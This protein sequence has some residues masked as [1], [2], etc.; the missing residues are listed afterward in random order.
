MTDEVREVKR[1][2]ASSLTGRSELTYEF[3]YHEQ[4]KTFRFRLKENSGTGHFQDHWISLEFILEILENQNAAFNLDVFRPLYDGSV[5]GLGFLAACLLNEQVLVRSQRK[6][7][8]RDTKEFLAGLNKLT[9]TIPAK[10][11]QA[12]KKSRKP[13]PEPQQ[14]E[15]QP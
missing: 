7:E 14:P 2:T 4:S 3:G 9:G 12:P 8:A 6:Y 13:S 1:S 15:E 10:Q 5:N 11:R